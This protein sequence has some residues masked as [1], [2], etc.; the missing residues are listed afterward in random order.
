MKIKQRFSFRIKATWIV[1]ILLTSMSFFTQAQHMFFHLLGSGLDPY[2][3]V[4]LGV[5]SNWNTSANWYG[6]QAPGVSNTALFDQN[7]LANCDPTINV[8]I[9]ILGLQMKSSYSGTITQAS[10]QAIA[11][12]AGGWN[13][14]AGTFIG[15][16]ASISISGNFVGSAGSFTSTSS[17]LDLRLGVSIAAMTFTHNSGVVDLNLNCVAVDFNLGVK[18]LND[19][20]IVGQ[21]GTVNLQ[22]SVITILGDLL[23]AD[24]NGG[25]LNNGTL[26]VEGDFRFNHYA[27]SGSAVV[28]LTG[29]GPQLVE[30]IAIPGLQERPLLPN[31]EIE[32]TGG[33]T[34]TFNG[35]IN[36]TRNYIFTSGLVNFGTSSWHFQ[37]DCSTRTIRPGTFN[38]PDVTIAHSCGTLEL[39]GQELKVFGKLTL[40]SA[41]VG[42]F[43]NGSIAAYGDVEQTGIHGLLDASPRTA[44]LRIVGSGNQTITGGTGRF[45]KME[46]ASSGGTVSFVNTINLMSD[47]TYTS[48]T[49]DFGT[50]T[51]VFGGNG[52]FIPGAIAYNNV[53][54]AGSGT[55]INLQ[56]N[57][58]LISG[59]TTF[60][61]S[62]AAPGSVSNGIIQASGHVVFS[63]FGKSGTSILN[64]VGATNTT[65]SV[66]VSASTLSTTH[67]IA[68]SG[69]GTVSLVAS[70][71]YSAIGRNFLITSGTFDLAGFNLSVNSLLTISAGGRLICNG[72]SATAGTWSIAG[73]ISCGSG[74]GITWTGASG[75]NLWSTSANWTNNTI[76]GPLDVA[77]FNNS[78]CVAAQCDAQINSNISVR[79]INMM[80]SYLGTLTQ[81]PTRQFTV[82]AGNFTQAGG[83]FAGGDSNFTTNGSF[84][85]SGGTFTSTSGLLVLNSHFAVSGAPVFTANSGTIF[86]SNTDTNSNINAGTIQFHHVTFSGNSADFTITGTMVVNGDLLI[87]DT[88]VLYT[89]SLLGGFISARGDVNVTGLG[90][91]GTTVLQ[92]AGAGNQT[93]NGG[94]GS[95]R[96]PS[97][98]IVS[99]GGIVL[100]TGTILFHNHFTFTSGSVDAG[101]STV[102]FYNA[103]SNSNLNT[104]PIEFNNVTFSGDSADFT[105][106]GALIVDGLLT[107]TDTHG[108]YTG[109]LFGGSIVAR[110]DVTVSGL[111]KYGTTVLQIAGS[112]N[113]TLTGGGG[114]ARLPTTQIISTGGTVTLSGTLLFHSH[115]T[116][117]SGAIDA[118]TSTVIFYNAD[119]TS[120]ISTGPIQFNDVVFSGDSADYSLTGTVVVDGHLTITD[121]NSTY[122]GSIN[123]G[124]VAA[125]GNVTVTG[126]GKYGTSLLLIEGGSNQVLSGAGT[127]TRW[128]PTQIASSGGTVSLSGTILFFYNFTYVS[129]TVDPGTSTVYFYNPNTTTTIT[130]GAMPF[131]NVTFAGDSADFNVVGTLTVNGT[132]VFADSNSSSI[133]S[134]NSGSIEAF[135]NITTESVGK[136]GGAS[137]IASGMTSTTFSIF[138]S[139]S[140]FP[141]GLLTVNKTG[142][143]QLLIGA[144]IALTTGQDVSIASGTLNLN[145]YDLTN[146]DSLTVAASTTLRCNGGVFTS[147]SLTNNGTINCPGFSTYEFNWTGAA[148]DSNWHTDGN[149]QGNLAPTA[150]DVAYFDDVNCGSNCNV[151][152]SSPLTAR[153]IQSGAGYTGIMTQANGVVIA[154]GRRGWVHGGGQVIGSNANMTIE[155]GLTVSGGNFQMTSATT[156][157]GTISCGTRTM[158]NYSGGTLSHNNGRLKIAHRRSPA[159]S[160]NST[161]NLSFPNGFSVYDFETEG[162]Y[163]AGWNSSIDPLNGTLLNVLNDYYDYGQTTNINIDLGRHLFVNKNNTI[164]TAHRIRMMGSVD[165]EYTY[166]PGSQVSNRL[167]VDKATGQVSSAPGNLNLSV[168]AFELLQGTFTA[169]SQTFTV[170]QDISTT[171][172]STIF[173]VAIG[174][175]FNH[176]NGLLKFAL[177]RC[178][179]CSANSTAHLSVPIGF[180]LYNV[181]VFAWGTAPG[182]S[183]TYSST[184]SIQVLNNF[185]HTGGR[186]NANWS[187]QGNVEFGSTVNG[188][189][190]TITLNGSGAQ[191]VTAYSGS[192]LPEGRWTINK[193]S[194]TVT[195]MGSGLSL[196]G[197]GQDFEL[198]SG[199]VNL[200]DSVLNVKDQLIVNTGSTLNC[201]SGYYLYTTLTNNGT[202]SCGTDNYV[203]SVLTTG[204]GPKIFLRLN[205]P[206]ATFPLGDSSKSGSYRGSFQVGSN[207][208]F[209]VDRSTN[210]MTEES[211]TTASNGYADTG[212]VVPLAATY[213]LEAWFKY[214]LAANGS[215]NT[216]FRGTDHQVI[217]NRSNMQLGMYDNVGGTLFRSTGFNVTNLSNGWHHLVVIGSGSSM[218]FYID[219]VNVGSIPIKSTDPIRYI[220]NIHTGGQSFGNID[221]VAIYDFALTQGQIDDHYNKGYPVK[222]AV[223]WMDDSI[224][225]GA[226]AVTTS[227]SWNFV[228]SNPT[229]NSGSFAHKS[230][231]F[232]GI[233]QHYFSGASTPFQ[234]YLGDVFYIDVF[235]DP[236]NPPQQLMLQ[237]YDGDWEQRVYWGANLIP[238]G[239]NGTN[240]RRYKGPLPPTGQWV[241]LTFDP[242]DVGLT[243][244]S[245]NGLAFS[246]SDG[247]VTWDQFGVLR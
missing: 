77:I 107:I 205:E 240:S 116:Y 213:T 229:P 245:I 12:G 223:A 176:N 48:G 22:S 1:A 142:A 41:F 7:C 55:T 243:A 56:T 57:T 125:R 241:R 207:I 212:S 115:F 16:D 230:D 166:T 9:N 247:Q 72:G 224:P 126:L 100:L 103:D 153:G 45:P 181:E 70:V 88:H 141:T 92:I 163:A 178:T 150:T 43:S 111:G 5:D 94:G 23:L 129:G 20:R 15:S 147:I 82:G 36:L 87:T 58:V 143:G 157:L 173:N 186:L 101:T 121:T 225:A 228:S 30:N 200:N 174:T 172:T 140:R 132:L 232:A 196:L 47:W 105:I 112:G 53:T 169:P 27:S 113:Q 159:A 160:C 90:K 235:L 71:N 85:L 64:F 184:N 51:L 188:G 33:S 104:G 34:A 26:E 93:I 211:I 204:I 28:K 179:A 190:G 73:E 198:I 180:S 189:T 152:I 234:T 86:F 177:S 78:I 144:D 119:S 117:T 219:K 162:S 193:P 95:A 214:P 199:S 65:L 35:R 158:L 244:Q 246:L 208:T 220:G 118:G 79:G 148:L 62:S 218:S 59:T 201:N 46:I 149:W 127:S 3:W 151:T 155:G 145:G 14:A 61:D 67:N 133:G 233:H 227:D 19:F 24:T 237:L 185:T 146:I 31:L 203:K 136:S 197:T 217:V 83:T 120:N 210:L 74:Q 222:S 2:T 231:L 29:A 138:E 37:Q 192:F 156:T 114:S 63:S 137:L 183:S 187:I 42:M 106:T 76:P 25:I 194:G 40:A 134:V 131:F 124:T 50:S 32:K 81:N 130:P 8:P 242:A 17:T 161:A 226:T 18:T 221:D 84:T 110:G 11:V 66:G 215:W 139:T 13:Q 52:N 238:W 171:I 128:L 75:D 68:K 98:Q 167:I 10:G 89:G 54:F 216:L 91:Y 44:T 206:A 236:T 4:G 69:A 135:G 202:I 80:S 164:N 175:T 182:W 108:L 170:G 239:T 49:L 6:N 60:A 195:M 97:T 21:C 99:T 38:Y 191:V 39:G 109:S 165:Q 168:F 123:G 209:G 154:L 122:T 102:I 96:M